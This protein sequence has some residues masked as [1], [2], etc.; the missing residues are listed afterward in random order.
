M[1]ITP[2]LTQDIL[3]HMMVFMPDPML[4][5]LLLVSHKMRSLAWEVC[6]RRSIIPH[7]WDVPRQTLQAALFK[8][9]KGLLTLLHTD[10][11]LCAVIGV[12]SAKGVLNHLS[13]DIYSLSARMGIVGDTTNEE[14]LI[15]A[16]RIG[17]N[18]IFAKE[19]AQKPPLYGRELRQAIKWSPSEEISSLLNVRAHTYK[20]LYDLI[21][22]RDIDAI[23]AMPLK[24]TKMAVAVTEVLAEWLM[25]LDNRSLTTAVCR[26]SADLVS[27]IDRKKPAFR[28]KGYNFDKIFIW[29]THLDR[30][31][32][33]IMRNAIICVDDPIFSTICD[34]TELRKAAIRSCCFKLAAACTFADT[35]DS[36]SD[37][38]WQYRIA[39]QHNKSPIQDNLI[40][41]Y[42]HTVDPIALYSW[43]YGTEQ[44]C[45]GAVTQNVPLRKKAIRAM[46]DHCAAQLAE[47]EEIGPSRLVE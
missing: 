25:Y 19:T 14:I 38:D 18:S 35:T 36:S 39:N 43:F 44:W 46:M 33:S 26:H 6:K 47:L 30:L 27:M 41:A 32:K 17:L 40:A 15:K 42:L 9:H 31:P 10:Y 45:V 2:T 5:K 4:V 37:D 13:E 24:K 21:H 20:K 12:T 29:D 7:L 22:K 8:S 3:C 16:A 1:D 23:R 28:H 34:H 11:A